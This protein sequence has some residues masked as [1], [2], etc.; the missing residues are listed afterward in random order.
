MNNEVFHERSLVEN[1]IF[2][3]VNILLL[4]PTYFTN[5]TLNNIDFKT[6]RNIK[7]PIFTEMFIEATSFMSSEKLRHKINEEILR[8]KLHLFVQ[9]VAILKTSE[10]L[11]KL[12]LVEAIY[13]LA[14]SCPVN[15][16]NGTCLWF[17]E[18]QC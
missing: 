14:A 8:A 16:C 10:S 18:E 13:N 9:W 15:I 1:F 3:A 12:F 2:C 4:L 11:Q 17:S 6:W 7:M 5:N